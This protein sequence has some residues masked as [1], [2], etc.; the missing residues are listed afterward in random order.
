MYAAI[1]QSITTKYPMIQY[2]GIM[3]YHETHC[4]QSMTITLKTHVLIK[5]N[6]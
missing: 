2:S 3:L 1:Q 5:D 6:N 4:Y